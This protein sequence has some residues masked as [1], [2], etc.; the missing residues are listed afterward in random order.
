MLVET[1]PCTYYTGLVATGKYGKLCD[2]K[3]KPK[4]PLHKQTC[5][6]LNNL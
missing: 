2:T 5:L 1:S 6:G 4:T 3:K